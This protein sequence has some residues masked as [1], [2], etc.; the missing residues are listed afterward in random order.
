MGGADVVQCL[1]DQAFTLRC[2]K[3]G[4]TFEVRIEAPFVFVPADGAAVTLDP[5]TDPVGLGPVLGCV[6]T[7]VAE[8]TAGEDGSLDVLFADGGALRVPGSG[9]AAF[10]AWILTGPAGLLVVSVPGGGLT[11]WGQQMR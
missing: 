10:E 5:E 6:R 9:S 8:A 2:D 3:A 1:V 7:A 11:T 4:E